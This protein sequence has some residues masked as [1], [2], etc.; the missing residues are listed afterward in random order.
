MLEETVVVRLAM[1]FFRLH[2][3]R[4][5]SLFFIVII[6]FI[7]F[8]IQLFPFLSMFEILKSH[9]DSGAVSHWKY[10]FAK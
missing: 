7:P 10:I 9:P 8:L 2:I 6:H 3:Y 4:V 5:I 1:L